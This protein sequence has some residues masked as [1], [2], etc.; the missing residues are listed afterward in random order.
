MKLLRMIAPE[1]LYYCV[2]IFVR[3]V[4]GA[5]ILSYFCKKIFTLYSFHHFYIL[6]GKTGTQPWY[7]YTEI[8]NISHYQ[9]TSDGYMYFISQQLIRNTIVNMHAM[10]V[11]GYPVHMFHALKLTFSIDKCMLNVQ[12]S[13][14]FFIIHGYFRSYVHGY[15]ASMI[16][17]RT[18]FIITVHVYKI[19]RNTALY[20]MHSY[21]DAA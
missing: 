5:C 9:R 3:Y 7:T 12:Q 14:L 8:L 1:L 21:K 15:M 4:N 16:D 2:D 6:S 19:F 11:H 20:I 17:R 18:N 13:Q 10:G